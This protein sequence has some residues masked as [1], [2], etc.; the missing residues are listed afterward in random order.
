MLVGSTK[1]P[2]S[3]VDRIPIIAQHA[4]SERAKETLNLVILILFCH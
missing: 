4:V 1:K 2:Q 3:A